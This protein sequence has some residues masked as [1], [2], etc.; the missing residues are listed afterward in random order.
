LC[1]APVTVA[2]TFVDSRFDLPLNMGGH[3]PA[4]VFVR[5]S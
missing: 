5:H 2:K 1:K 3:G 4:G